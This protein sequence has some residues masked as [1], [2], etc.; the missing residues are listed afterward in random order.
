MTP[1][2]ARCASAAWTCGT[3][4]WKNLR[5][6]VSMVLQNGTLFSGTIASNLRWGQTRRD[7]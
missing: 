6:G 2:P 7:A 5:D 3:T 1:F 4:R